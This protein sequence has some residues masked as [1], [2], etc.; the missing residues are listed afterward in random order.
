MC[1]NKFFFYAGEINGNKG[2]F[3]NLKRGIINDIDGGPNLQY[4]T[5]Y[6][7]EDNTM[8]AWVDAYKLIAYVQSD[9]FKNSTPKY[10]EKKR[11]LEQLADNLS[12]NDNPVLMLVKLKE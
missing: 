8:L 10:P 5:I 12:E 11:E 3:G 6:Y 4:H 1:H 7:F 9:V 2:H